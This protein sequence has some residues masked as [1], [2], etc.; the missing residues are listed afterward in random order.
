MPDVIQSRLNKALKDKW[1]LIFQVPEGLQDLIKENLTGKD[2]LDLNALQYSLVSF[3]SPDITVKAISQ[4]YGSGNLYV[5]SHS[6]D[7]FELLSIKFKVDNRYAN[8]AVIYEWLNLL[9]D[10]KEA[11]P[12]PRNLMGKRLHVDTYWTNL[13]LLCLDEYNN[14]KLQFTYTKAFPTKISGIDFDY[15]NTDEIEATVNFAFSQFHV[16]Y[17]DDKNRQQFK[18]S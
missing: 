16:T 5:S 10:E 18:I 2:T 4:R 13:A 15:T 12:D 11:I 14:V 1:V 17:P 8:W 9:H 6:K 3:N 7:P